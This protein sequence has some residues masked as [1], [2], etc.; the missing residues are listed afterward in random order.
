MRITVR[1]KIGL[2]LGILSAL[3]L[4]FGLITLLV[5]RSI[6]HRI[7][8]ITETKEP[9]KAA[10]YEMQLN[11]MGTGLAVLNYLRDHDPRDL[12]QIDRFGAEF[13][14]VRK[15][16]HAVATTAPPDELRNQLDSQYALFR[17]L[18]D[19]LLA[20]DAEISRNMD[21]YLKVSRL[22]QEHFASEIRRLSQTGGARAAKRIALTAEMAA[23][24]RVM[25]SDIQAGRSRTIEH[26]SGFKKEIESFKRNLQA[27]RIISSANLRWTDKVGRQLIELETLGREIDDL[28][29]TNQSALLRFLTLRKDLAV[30]LNQEI[31]EPTQLSLSDSKAGALAT[32]RR[33]SEL[34]FLTLAFSVPFGISAAILST[35]GIVKPVNMLVAAMNSIAKGDLSTRVNLRSSDEIGFLGESL[36]RMTQDLRES[37]VSRK[38]VE[39]ILHS[40]SESL[41]VVS[42]DDKIEMVNGATCLLSGYQMEELIGQNVGMTFLGEAFKAAQD[43]GLGNRECVTNIESIFP[44]RDGSLIP[45]CSPAL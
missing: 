38:Y 41:I 9:I 22:T 39:R 26:K 27:Y 32:V 14:R 28:A 20:R 43:A 36:N 3:F 37:T 5:M 18:F 16:A 23:S 15:N 35:A 1:A 13:E 33:G 17:S 12:D 25:E 7:Q 24:A 6:T 45:C 10:A 29:K 11:L 4:S 30:T 44:R 8:E 2:A 21:T 31:Q 34:I 19:E 42:P 40:M